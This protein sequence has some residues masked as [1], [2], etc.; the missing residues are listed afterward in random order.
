MKPRKA[1]AAVKAGTP[2]SSAKTDQAEESFLVVEYEGLSHRVEAD[3][4]LS[5]GREADVSVG[6]NPYLHRRL[7]VLANEHDFW[8]LANVGSRI[9]CTVADLRSRTHSWLS[10]GARLPVVFRETA[11]MFTAG[12]CT[13]ELAIF[14]EHPV[15]HN[16]LDAQ[17]ST[18]ATTLGSIPFTLSQRQLIVALAEPLLRR[19]GAGMNQVRSSAEAAERLGWPLS[20]FNRKLDNV[21]DK[22]DRFGVEGMRGGPAA[23][24]AHRRAAL[25]E[26]AVTTGLVAPVDL[27]LLDQTGLEDE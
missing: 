12:P 10:P 14:N 25:V 9:T 4:T 1:D 22:L 8:W 5:V 6:D 15:V 23:R 21:C 2:S 7:L 17:A 13:Y 11:V 16:P 26:Y 19:T 18:G 20:R 27:L 3:R 24:A